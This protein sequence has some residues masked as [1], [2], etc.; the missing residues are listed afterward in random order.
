[1]RY[2]E[3]GGKGPGWVKTAGNRCCC[4]FTGGAMQDRCCCLSLS[5]SLVLLLWNSVPSRPVYLYLVIRYYCLFLV[6]HLVSVIFSLYFLIIMCRILSSRTNHPR[7]VHFSLP[8]C[9]FNFVL[10]FRT[11]YSF[12]FL[13]LGVLLTI[14]CLCWCILLPRHT[15]LSSCRKHKQI[16]C[17]YWMA[18]RVEI[19]GGTN[20]NRIKNYQGRKFRL[21][22]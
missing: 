17:I 20:C 11:W 3:S 22:K 15:Y 14:S 7:F 5:I 9:V 10:L 4:G 18:V 21:D 12:I 8:L 16:I 19:S 1:M 2:G 6:S 13:Q